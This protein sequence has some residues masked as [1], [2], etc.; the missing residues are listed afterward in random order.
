M[1]PVVIHKRWW[2]P[3]WGH[4][5]GIALY[6]LIF[7][8]EP[9]R[10]TTLRHEL[11][12]CWQVQRVGWLRF[13][14]VWLWQRVTRGYRSIEVEEEAYLNEGDRYYLPDHLEALVK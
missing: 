8:R 4:T 7:I 10:L 6:P 5:V 11:I 9:Y 3:P 13:Y 2:T 12:H 1:K 14:V